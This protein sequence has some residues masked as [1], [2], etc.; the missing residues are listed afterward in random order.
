MSFLKKIFK[1]GLGIVVGFILLLFIAALTVDTD[2]V[3]TGINKIKV[4]DE[5]NTEKDDSDVVAQGTYAV[6]DRVIVGE[7]AYTITEVD[8]DDDDPTWIDL[9]VEFENLGDD[10]REYYDPD[11]N[12]KLISEK[13]Q[14][15]EPL[16]GY[17]TWERGLDELRP[18]IPMEVYIVFE[19]PRGQMYYAEVG[20]SFCDDGKKIDI[21]MVPK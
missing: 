3:D 10:T 6:G 13:G 18:G 12:V 14:T 8:I 15:Y 7:V 21:G 16:N 5:S 11:D 20:D 19:V 2:S 17:T 1:I 4:V 9:G